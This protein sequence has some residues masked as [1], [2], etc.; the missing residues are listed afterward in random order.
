MSVRATSLSLP[1]SEAAHEAV[2]SSEYRADIDGLRA[3]AI[4]GVLCVHA[5]PD[6][7]TGG[8][9]GVDI[10]FVISG[11][12]ISGIIFRALA[13]GSFNCFNFYMRRVLRI[14]PALILILIAVWVFGWLTLRPNEF[15]YLGKY[16]MAG[17]GFVVNFTRYADIPE[18]WGPALSLPHLWSLSVEEQFYLVWPLFLL[19]TWRLG[20][21]QFMAIALIT[22][23]SFMLF[24]TA[25]R[26]V[27]YLFPWNRLWELSAGGAVACAQ[28]WEIGR[29]DRRRRSSA[30]SLIQWWL[31]PHVRGLAGAALIIASYVGINERTLETWWW[32]LPSCT[33][34]CLLVSAGPQS[35]INR[36]VLGAAPMVFIGRISYPLYLWHF[37]LLVAAYFP[38]KAT[39]VPMLTVKLGSLGLA[40]ALASL[41]YKCIELPIRSIAKKTQLAFTLCGIMALCGIA[42]YM[43]FIQK[44]TTRANNHVDGSATT[45]YVIRSHSP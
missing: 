44:I 10:F 29:E 26:H 15:R 28:V 12:L 16:V 4:L 5:F 30:P 42:G 3:V 36:H 7:L 9:T 1:V 17:A 2:S 13:D 39:P 31:S 43:T 45:S 34:A 14:F 25:S 19:A 41:T 35:W 40:V 8:G 11:F 38:Y 18:V 37:P 22:A 24:A 32:A 23:V 21:R 33:G 20:G 27:A 6:L